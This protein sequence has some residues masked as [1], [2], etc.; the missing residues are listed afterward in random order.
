MQLPSYLNES[1]KVFKGKKISLYSPEFISKSGKPYRHDIITHPGAVVILP[2]LDEKTILLIKNYRVAIDEHLYEL[3]AG[4][5]EKDEAPELTATRELLEE[6]GYQAK[7][8]TKALDFY[9]T[10][11][12]TNELLHGFIA[13]DL[14]FNGQELEDSEQIE[15]I[16]TPFSQA[17]SM[18]QSGEIKDAKSILLLLYARHESCLRL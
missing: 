11:G 17:L 5:L 8:M 6:T 12:F 14:I 13:K 2:F 9:S 15:V 3:P 7:T 18:I 10:P 1:T 4:T 16:P